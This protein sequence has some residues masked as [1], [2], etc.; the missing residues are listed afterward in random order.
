MEGP[1]PLTCP[2]VQGGV[3]APGTRA[4]PRI[5]T[6]RDCA[7]SRAPNSPGLFPA[8]VPPHAVPCPAPTAP[9]AARTHT[10]EPWVQDHVSQQADHRVQA[11]RI[12]RHS[13]HG[14]VPGKTNNASAAVTPWTRG[15]ALLS[16]GVA[17]KHMFGAVPCPRLLGREELLAGGTPAAPRSVPSESPSGQSGREARGAPSSTGPA[18]ANR[19]IPGRMRPAQM[20][21]H[22]G[23][24]LAPDGGGQRPAAAAAAAAAHR[25]RGHC[26][27]WAGCISREGTAT[28][29]V[30]RNR[31]GRGRECPWGQTWPPAPLQRRATLSG[32]AGRGGAAGMEARAEGAWGRQSQDSGLL[33]PEPGARRV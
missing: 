5:F 3:G 24:G 28:G 29:E 6:P 22:C 10:C 27:Q 13:V 15:R 14:G 4:F 19:H 33:D 20:T 18:T 30:T 31:H 26:G 8:A 1:S 2:R 25:M 16:L 17:R 23:N 32:A 7:H 11:S 12:G 21:G 9:Q